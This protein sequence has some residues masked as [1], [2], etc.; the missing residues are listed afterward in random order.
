MVKQAFD[1]IAGNTVVPYQSL[2]KFI[3]HHKT[4]YFAIY[5]NFCQIVLKSDFKK[6]SYGQDMILL[7][8][9]AVT[10]T[11]NVAT[12]MLQVMRRHNMVII[13]VK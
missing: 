1:S 11:F 7:Q 8:G 4:L 2:K 3:N 9:H 13:S 5:N 6:Q 10:L 12:Q